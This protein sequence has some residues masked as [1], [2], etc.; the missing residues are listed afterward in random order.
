MFKRSILAL[1][2]AVVAFNAHAVSSGDL[3]F[4]AF[5]AD[6]DGWSLV[7]FVDLAA[8]SQFYF[9]DNDGTAL[10]STAV[11]ATTPGTPAAA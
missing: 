9:T 7:T 1:A 3:A 4:T 8:N 6:E 10:P 11:R 5:N 2:T